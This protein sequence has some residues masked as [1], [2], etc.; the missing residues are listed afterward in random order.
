MSTTTEN[1]VSDGATT[2]TV[3]SARPDELAAVGELTVAGFSVGPYPPDAARAALLRDAAGRART[4]DVRVAV[5]G[6]GEDLLG[7]A[8]LAP[9]GTEHARFAGPDELEFRLLAVS[10]AARRRGLGALLLEDA[11]AQARARGFTRVVLDTGARNETAQRLYHR[12]GFTRLPERED[13]LGGGGLRLAVFGRD[14]DPAPGVLVRLARPGELDAVSRLALDAYAADG[15]LPDWYAAQVADAATRTREA[16]L[17]VAVDAVTGELLGTVTLPRP[18]RTLSATA[19]DGELDLRLLASAVPAR[20]RGVGTALVR[21]ALDVARW[22][23]LHRVV[24]NSAPRMT[25]AHSLYTTL[26]FVRL[27]ERETRVVEG[28]TLLAFGYDVVPLAG[29]DTL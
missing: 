17:W 26:G 27:P 20:G 11:V 8:T 7:T 3:R 24:L 21:H 25:A 4:A 18:G 19:L 13:R 2:L 9:G 29:D 23:G 22:R 14:V 28:G 6:T 10:P 15:D 16:E 12:S 5:E 1:P